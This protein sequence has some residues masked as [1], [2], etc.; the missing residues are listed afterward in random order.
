M[1]RSLVPSA[2]KSHT[3]ASASAASA[4]PPPDAP[5]PSARRIVARGKHVLVV[6]GARVSVPHGQPFPEGF[7]VST[8][9]P[10]SYAFEGDPSR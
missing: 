1:V 4:A 10:G 9:P 8:L 2:K 3:R 5:P 7:D 6:D